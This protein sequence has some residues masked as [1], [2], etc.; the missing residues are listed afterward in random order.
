MTAIGRWLGL[1]HRVGGLVSYLIL[2]YKGTVI[3]ITTVQLLSSL[4]KDK[5]E[6]KASVGEFD[7]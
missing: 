5:D 7:T 4:E 3:L 2:A 1:S 6:V